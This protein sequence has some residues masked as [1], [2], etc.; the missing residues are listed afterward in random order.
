M[1]SYIQPPTRVN[2]NKH[3]D[4]ILDY[5]PPDGREHFKTRCFEL[6]L[7]RNMKLKLEKDPNRPHLNLFRVYLATTGVRTITDE[8]IRNCGGCLLAVFLCPIR[9]SQCVSDIDSLFDKVEGELAP[10]VVSGD[11]VILLLD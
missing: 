4:F 2:T 3:I 10:F 7:V 6:P 1:S 9:P 8:Q 11:T 5:I